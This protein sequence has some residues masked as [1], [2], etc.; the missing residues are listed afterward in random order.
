MC[1]CVWGGGTS[2]NSG[3]ESVGGHKH[4]FALHSEK[5]GGG[6]MPPCPPPPR[7]LRQWHDTRRNMTM[8]EQGAYHVVAVG[9]ER[10]APMHA[11]GL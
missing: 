5:W 9:A 2:L 10:A 3:S 8:P 6:H 11:V 1:V 7:F 4:I